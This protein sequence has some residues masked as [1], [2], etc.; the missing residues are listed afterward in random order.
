MIGHGATTLA[1]MRALTP[2]TGA[3]LHIWLRP[4]KEAL[5][6]YNRW[7]KSLKRG[8]GCVGGTD[9]LIIQAKHPGSLLCFLQ[10]LNWRLLAVDYAT[11]ALLRRRGRGQRRDKVK[12]T[13]GNDSKST[14]TPRKSS[15]ILPVQHKNRPAAKQC[16][17]LKPGVT[18]HLVT[19]HPRI[20]FWTRHIVDNT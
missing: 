17:R 1:C 18:R 2:N 7:Y 16:Q 10:R 20:H 3:M 19:F 13:R 12:R 15:V 9:V 8:G 5:I 14:K 11:Q 6:H 4:E